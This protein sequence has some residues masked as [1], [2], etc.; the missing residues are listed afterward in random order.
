[1]LARDYRSL[2]DEIGTLNAHILGMSKR[3]DEAGEKFRKT[4]REIVLQ[5][6][7]M[8]CADRGNGGWEKRIAWM[9]GEF[10]RQ[11]SPVS[12]TGDSQ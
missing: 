2:L 9:L 7:S 4:E 10:E 12:E 11:G 1:M 6:Q 5:L 3:L 8:D